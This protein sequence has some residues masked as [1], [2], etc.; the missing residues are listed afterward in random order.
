MRRKSGVLLVTAF[1]TAALL[2]AQ[3][4]NKKYRTSPTGYRDTPLLPGQ[5]WKVHDI[6]RP[7]PR[8]VTPGAG[9][10]MPPS[11]AIVLF[12]G[13]DLSQWMNERKGQLVPA[14]WKVENGY[15]EVA[16]GAGT[17][18]S[19][20]KFGDA[21]FHLE[22]AA[23]VEPSGDS[24]WRANSGVLL[25]KRYEIQVLDCYNNPTYADGQAA[26]IYGQWPPLVN[27]CRKPGEW[28][29]YDIVFEAPKFEG[30]KL[31]KPA[32]VTVF[33]NGVLVHHHQEIIGRMAH[34][35][36]GTYAPHAPE[37]PLALQDHDVPVRYRNI[38]VRRLRGYDE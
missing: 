5:K 35:V 26:S 24:Q 38:W 36:V 11:D 3:S 34:R 15:M 23:P 6:D 29:S 10:G 22:W 17:L 1:C 9:P 27:A 18:V 21:Q 28:Q 4:S 2:I 32:Y 19:K 12:D 7:K 25:M 31:V 16:P 33:H 37:E 13:K 30:E 14:A 20:E 8:I